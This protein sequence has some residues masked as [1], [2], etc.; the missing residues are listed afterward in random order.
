[1]DVPDNNTKS[2]EEAMSSFSMSHYDPNNPNDI[3]D[4]TPTPRKAFHTD[5]KLCQSI[6][7]S[8]TVTGA[9]K[10]E[11]KSSEAGSGSGLFVASGGVPPVHAGGIEPGR[12]V[13]RSTPVMW[14]LDHDG[15]GSSGG[16]R[17]SQ[18][19]CEEC[20]RDGDQV[21]A[22]GGCLVVKFCGKV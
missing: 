5:Q 10:L 1:M 15:Y 22:C 19:W 8:A 18:G 17:G 13:Y 11:I 12:E 9:V 4:F 16:G 2:L 14:A 21:K 3:Q 7:S 6:L 20:G